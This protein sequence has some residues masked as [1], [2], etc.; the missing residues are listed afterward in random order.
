MNSD[1]SDTFRLNCGS[2]H[3]STVSGPFFPVSLEASTPSYP[4]VQLQWDDCRQHLLR[5]VTG[6]G[7]RYFLFCLAESWI[8]TKRKS[9]S[10]TPQQ[11]HYL[12]IQRLITW[13]HEIILG[14]KSHSHLSIKRMEKQ[15]DSSVSTGCFMYPRGLSIANTNPRCL[16]V[17]IKFRRKLST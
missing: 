5:V 2:Y 11:K 12:P 14:C 3:Y 9:I 8:I 6:P 7:E 13:V 1:R 4:V 17:P 15:W 10:L 16:R